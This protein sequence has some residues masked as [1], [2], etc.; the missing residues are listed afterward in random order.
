MRLINQLSQPLC[1]EDGTILAAAG[2]EG[3]AKRVKELSEKDGKRY[4]ARGYVAV[5]EDQAPRPAA[6]ARKKEE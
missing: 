1:L 5:V 3:S 6:S 2:T 4:V